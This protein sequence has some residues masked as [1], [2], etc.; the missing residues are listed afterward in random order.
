MK[1]LEFLILPKQI[2]S[3]EAGYLRRLNRVAL[4]FFAMHVPVF[5]LVAW[6]NH[7]RPA[8]AALLTTAVLAGPAIAYLTLKNPRTVSVIH[9]VA[10]MFMGGLLVHFGQGPVQIEMH[11]YFFALVAMC[12]VFG[13]PLV[14]VA[15]TVTVA[16][17][18]LVV[19]WVLPQSG[20]NYDAAWWVVAVHAAFVVLEAIATCFISRSFF[21]NV[22]GLE[23][24]VQDRT[25]ALDAKNLDMRL[26]LDNVAQGL[27][28]VDRDGAIAEERSKAI[29]E[30]FFTPKA[31]T[32]M[33]DLFQHVSPAVR[34]SLA[35]GWEQAFDGILPLELALSQMPHRIRSGEVYFEVAYEPILKN[36]ELD[37][38]LIVVSDVTAAVEAEHAEVE[39]REL[40][41]L[42][43]AIAKDRTGVSD[44]LKDTG[45]LVMKVWDHGADG[46]MST[47]VK[48]AIHTIKGN[49]GLVGIV[50][51][52]AL[53][54]D[55][56]TRMA[57]ADPEE[58]VPAMD[59]GALLH[60]WQTMEGR[61]RDLL[62]DVT[63]AS[64]IDVSETDVAHL[65]AS[66]QQGKSG[67]A[68]IHSLATW[69]MDP[70]DKRLARLADRAKQLAVRMGKSG[71]TIDVKPTSLR[72]PAERWAPFWG[73]LPHVISNALDHGIEEADERKAAGKPEHGRVILSTVERGEQVIIEIADDGRGINWTKL[74]EKAA[75]LGLPSE[76]QRELVVALFT[77][78]VTTKDEASQF[79]GRGVGLAAVR[80]ACEELGGTI[81]V[82]SAIGLGTK[83]RFSFP[84]PEVASALAKLREVS[85]ERRVTASL[86]SFPAMQVPRTPS[87][88]F[89]TSPSVAP[90]ARV[91]VI[92]A[93]MKAVR[94]AS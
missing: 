45:K 40:M 49:C 52:S 28:T 63:S 65:A 26:V 60:T 43:G 39:Q 51:L 72:L 48:R 8:L 73:V 16:L 67:E 70:V 93:S 27:V 44:F 81:D 86:P 1:V 24:I 11:F 10:A 14:I 13:N 30:W 56:E 87:S 75:D 12:A 88:Q 22:I 53:C 94:A 64:A 37:K 78:G 71:V 34:A 17:H 6:C 91:S 54:H 58:G 57:E 31:G 29:D 33:W 32:K 7:T 61:A 38:C 47:E 42:F 46:S 77:D 92:P 25:L 21:D 89:R 4:A 66:I 5:V 55:I 74:R 79:S 41:S 9:G 2:T 62:G 18:H 23:K 82:E 76:T 35:V 90:R 69:F 36:G 85:P 3:F 15:A 59:R 84:L 68:L 80:T 20:F 19:W 83:L 50:S